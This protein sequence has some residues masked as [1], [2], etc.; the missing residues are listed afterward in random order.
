MMP[1]TFGSNRQT[2]QLPRKTN[3]KIADIDHLLHF[4]QAFGK[5]LPAFERH[6]LAEF[7]LVPA[8]FFAEQADQFAALRRRNVAPHIEGF[9]GILD[10][11]VERG[12]AVAFQ[13]CQL[14]A[15][16]RRHDRQIAPVLLFQ[17]DAEFA[18][19]AETIS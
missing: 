9:R 16:D 2:I 19:K 6:K 11:G 3:R 4:A 13:A 17:I 10:L 12:G 18:E 5:N 7:V 15:V 1:R 8:Q 14:A